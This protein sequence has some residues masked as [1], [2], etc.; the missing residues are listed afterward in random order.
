MNAMNDDE[1]QQQKNNNDDASTSSTSTSI[2]EIRLSVEGMMCQR[3][4]GTTVENA[5]LSIKGAI[6]SKAIF[7]LAF[8]SVTIDLNIAQ[9][10]DDKTVTVHDFNKLEDIV[11]ETI[12]NI[13]FDCRVLD[14]NE[15]LVPRE[16]KNND[17]VFTIDDVTDDNDNDNNDNN[18][19]QAIYQ[20]IGMSCT[21][22]TT[23][24]ERALLSTSYINTA[25]VNLSS[26]Q[27]KVQL[28]HPISNVD[29]CAALV[30]SLGYTCRTMQVKD[31]NTNKIL[32]NNITNDPS[33][34]L[35]P[36]KEEMKAWLHLLIVSCVFTIPLMFIHF[37]TMKNVQASMMDGQP[38]CLNEWIMLLLSTPVQ[39]YVGKRFYIAAYRNVM[40]GCILGMDALIVLGTTASY[41]YSII[42]FTLQYTNS[43]NH[44]NSH[45]GTFT[46]PTFETSAMLLTFVTFG[47]YLEAYAKGKT[48]QALYKLLELQPSNALKVTNHIDNNMINIPSLQTISISLDQVHANDYLLV[49]PGNRIP[50]DGILVATSSSSSSTSSEGSSHNNTVYVDESAFSG[51]PFPIPK[52]IGDTLIGSSLNQLSTIVIQVTA[53]G[54]DT[55]IS[56]IISCMED[57]QSQV[58]PIQNFAD[59]VASIFAPFVICCSII[60]FLSWKLVFIFTNSSHDMSSSEQFFN[61]FM[62]SISVI[63]VACPCALGLATPTA[64]MVGTGVG[65]SHGLLIKGGNVLEKAQSVDTIV[66][67][68]TGTITTGKAVLNRRYD[69]DND[70]LLQYNTN[71]PIEDNHNISLWLASCA[72]STSEHPLSIAI[73]N[74]A[75]SLW[76]ADYTHSMSDS[77]SV[78]NNQIYPGDGVECCVCQEDWGTFIIRVGRKDWVL[79]H[80]KE[81]SDLNHNDHIDPI[82]DNLAEQLRNEGQIVV[83]LSIKQLKS[84]T[85]TTTQ[86]KS[87]LNDQNNNNHQLE[88]KFQII[89]LFSIMDPIKSTAQPCIQTLLNMNIDVWMCTGDHELSAYHVAKE[90][91]IDRHNVCANVHPQGKADFIKR[92]QTP[93]DDNDDDDDDDNHIYYHGTSNHSLCTK[94]WNFICCRVT[95]NMQQPRIVAMVGDGINDAVAL[96]TADVGIAIGA[97]TEIAME[98]A[99]IVLI[100]NSLYDVITALH[101]SRKVFNRIKWNFFWALCYNICSLPIAAGILYPILKWKLSPAF[102]GLMMAFSSVSVVCSSLLLR[103]YNKPNIQVGK[104]G[105][106]LPPNKGLSIT[107]S[108]RS[109]SSSCFSCCCC[110]P[111]SFCCWSSSKGKY[112]T[113]TRNSSVED[114]LELL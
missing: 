108:E 56:Q 52:S 1:Q 34:V 107:T 97:G 60:T 40:H 26:C 46:S 77:V 16:K 75:K 17:A 22:C 112:N 57:A 44:T 59:K 11:I 78:T 48:A 37:T 105:K 98:A 27:A 3:N 93:S 45:H 51:E 114:G 84:N 18:G 15:E 89:S 90:V 87:S 30:Q 85:T 71:C 74:A 20:I 13:G 39:F 73:V 68:K 9:D 54:Q 24:V 99:S 88:Q 38:P 102:A 104:D 4:C 41:L 42:I 36:S 12:E 33:C 96:A 14:D 81:N 106:L 21:V 58:A 62:S 83:F 49:L 28:S 111:S 100:Q 110:N 19:I 70:L 91:G 65:A 55:V 31:K 7:D 82:G 32:K 103:C 76:G 2:K 80:N 43:N 79:D 8:A 63:V 92:L 113:I 23:K 95:N 101:L 53:T 64:V 109:D 61:A 5:L 94:L 66:F 72:E 86:I 69:L 35:D 50:T 47:K 25:R 10:C 6:Q 67:D 29:K